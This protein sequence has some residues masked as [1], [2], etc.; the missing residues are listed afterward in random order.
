MNKP[1][2]HFHLR[3]VPASK[4]NLI[5]SSHQIIEYIYSLK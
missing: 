3:P 2:K 4:G 5:H 1:S